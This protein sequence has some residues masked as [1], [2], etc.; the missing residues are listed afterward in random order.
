[1][2]KIKVGVSLD[3]SDIDTQ[4]KKIKPK[5]KVKIDVSA[6]ISNLERSINNVLGTLS[7]TE[8]KLSTT[9]ARR[10]IQKIAEDVDK[11]R[12]ITKTFDSSGN[13]LKIIDKTATKDITQ[14][15]KEL[16]A[17]YIKL[18][19]L[20]AKAKSPE[21]V[22]FLG[23]VKKAVDELD[24]SKVAETTIKLEQ[25]QQLVTQRSAEINKAVQQNKEYAK[26]QEEMERSIAKTREEID[27]Y[28]RQ[29][30]LMIGKAVTSGNMDL[31][32]AL[33][34]V[35][36]AVNDI[37]PTNV[38]KATKYLNELKEQAK[39][40]EMGMNALA[41]EEKKLA[42]AQEDIAN[43]T[44]ST[45]NAIDSFVDRL[46]VM[47]ERARVAG[48][49]DLANE[50]TKIQ[51][52][53]RN[54]DVNNLEQA[55]KSLEELKQNANL[56]T[57]ELNGVESQTKK[58]ESAME[59]LRNVMS[60]AEK[61]EL[62][63]SKEYVDAVSSLLKVE[64]ALE[65]IRATG[66]TIDISSTLN[67]A[68]DSANTLK[69][70]LDK[71]EDS[72][73]GVSSALSEIAQ[74]FGVYIDLG[75]IVQAVWQSFSN[76]IRT[77]AEIDG[78]MR[79][80]QK[81]CDGT[82]ESFERFP[83]VARETAKE[84]GATTEEI[85]RA[86]EYYAKL[87]NTLEESAEKAKLATIFKNIGDFS[88]IDMASEALITIQKGFK[89]IGDS[90]QDMIK[91]M[92]VANEVGNNFTSTTEDI[93]EGLR[94]S[95]NALSEANNTYEQSVGIFVA[96]N[97]SIQDAQKVGNAIKTIA[98]RLRG[99]ETELDACGVP[100]SKLR[101]EIYEITKT[102]GK[103]IDILKDDGLTFKSTYDIL[104]E[105]S[106][107]YD[108]LNDSQKA[109]LQQVIAGKQQGNVFSGIMENM[110]EGV[111]AYNT[112]LNSSGSAM[113][114]NEIY[115]DSVDAKMNQLSENVQKFWS[116]LVN[117]RMVKS[118]LDGLNSLMETVDNTSDIFGAS[119][120][121]IL[122]FGT[123]FSPAITGVVNL[124][125]K[126]GGLQTILGNLVTPLGIFLTT[127][128]LVAIG[129]G[130]ISELYKD[131]NERIAETSDALD[132]FNQRQKELENAQGLLDK[133]AKLERKI[134]DSNTS[135]EEK[136]QLEGEVKGIVEQLSTVN[137][138]ISDTLK[139]DNL[140]LLEKKGIIEDI[141]ALE[142]KENAE[143]LNDKLDNKKHYKNL[144][145]D[146]KR[147]Y[148]DIKIMEKE[149]AD[150][151]VGK[152][153]IATWTS[154]LEYKKEQLKDQYAEIALYNQSVSD[155]GTWA[156]EFGREIIV[157]DDNI[158]TFY[159]GLALAGE[160]ASVSGESLKGIS[161]EIGAIPMVAERSE[162]KVKE[163][164]DS[165]GA[166]DEIDLFND[167]S[168]LDLSLVSSEFTNLAT[169]VGKTADQLQR[170]L[171]TWN[172]LQGNKSTIEDIIKSI[173]ENG[174]LTDD[175]R[176]KIISSGNAD[177]IALLD[178]DD[179][180]GDLIEYQEKVNKQ[181]EEEERRIIETA[182]AQVEKNKVMDEQIEKERQR[183]DQI[184][185]MNETLQGTTVKDGTINDPSEKVKQIGEIVETASGA[186]LALAEL[187][188]QKVLLHY[189][190][191]GF[192]REVS[193]TKEV[194]DGLYA[195]MITLDGTNTVITIDENG[196]TA[197]YALENIKEKADGT[198]TA[199]T[200]IG[201]EEFYINFDAEGNVLDL[202]NVKETAEGLIGVF[203]GVD[204][205]SYKVTF[206][207]ETLEKDIVEV[208]ENIDGTYSLIDESSGHP[209]E[210]IMNGD[211]EVIG[212]IDGINSSIEELK[213]RKQHL[214]ESPITVTFEGKEY[215][216]SDLQNV[217]S[218]LD[219]TYTAIGT[220]NGQPVK[221]TFDNQGQIVGEIR[222]VTDS[223]N[224]A[225]DARHDLN[226]KPF[227]PTVTGADSAIDK[228][229]RVAD[230]A[231]YARS[232]AGTIRFVTENITVNA[233]ETRYS[234]GRSQGGH[235][236]YIQSIKT[237]SEDIFAPV[238]A[239]Q[240]VVIMANPV[241]DTSEV[242][243]FDVGG[244]ISESGGG[245]GFSAPIA[246][247][248]PFALKTKTESKDSSSSSS[249]Q[250]L[251]YEVDRYYKLN[252]ILED[253]E[254]ALKRI[255]DAKDIATGKQ[256]V[257]LIKQENETLAK[258]IQTL[259]LLQAEQEKELAE[260][261]ATLSANG[262][263]FDSYGNLINSQEKLVALA[264]WANEG[265]DSRNEHVEQL[266]DLVNLYTNLANKS[267]PDTQDA[268]RD[269]NKE[270]RDTAV[271]QL[272]ELREKLI[273]ALRTER[274]Q[275]KDAE[276]SILDNRIADL[277]KQIEDLDDDVSDRLTKRTKLEAE[278]K[279]WQKDDSAFSTKKQ[280][281]LQKELNDLNKQIRKDELEKQIQ[282]VEETKNTV[283]ETYDSMLE[284]K[285]LYEDANNLIT[286]GKTDE[287]LLL[288][289]E[290]A[291]DY[292]NIG[293]LW[294]ENLSNAFMEEIKLALE[295]LAYLKGESNKFT[296]NVNT[297]APPPQVS[298]PS[299]PTPTP[300]PATTSK[301]VSI[302]SRVKVTDVGAGIYVDSYTSQSS[303]TWRGA[304]VSTSD[305]MYVYNMRGDKV[306]LARSQGGVPIGWI[307]KKKVKA[308]DTGGY[309]GDFQGGQLA[310]L[311]SKERVLSAQ[312]T[313][314][315]EKLVAMLGD[316]VENPMLQLGQSTKSMGNPMTEINT[317]IEINNNFTVTNNTPFD[318]DRQDNNISQLMAKELRRFG[319]ITKK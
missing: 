4:L 103:P 292:K 220:L 110:T 236:A 219:G 45:Q 44:K 242:E 68:K 27:A 42:K 238:E 281:E 224:E 56:T 127:L 133:W 124:V 32:E 178:N 17:F 63:D 299:T 271:D 197:T 53:T 191:Q 274:E 100:A 185:E 151:K 205:K 31:A 66:A 297:S 282:E 136:V 315:F 206:D 319:K 139:N 276:I 187:N 96:A 159:E 166:L 118:A 168:D 128:S 13:L 30:N 94:R 216:V 106:A 86:T 49:L 215:V 37:D 312:Q 58:L 97:S 278:L 240:D 2:K 318:Q 149:L 7:T 104:V 134:K 196:E 311:H 270:L 137:S 147:N 14:M 29:L 15:Y 121:S 310:M 227:N 85:I 228:L 243:A 305:T 78:A 255:K 247:V 207:K 284:E 98:M 155:M 60:R 109:Y 189:D 135:L 61:F 57:V 174:Y 268:I 132:T 226:S 62:A 11:L 180:Y 28:T 309:T 90:G 39:L 256:Y 303:G 146:M 264:N 73:E 50:L 1:M 87:G 225:T 173:N 3:V 252:D 19:N 82:A 233:V 186:K 213:E 65:R 67:S 144:Y 253:Y 288:L 199:L 201:E 241:M 164:A 258:K 291:E 302:G 150:N 131:A 244:A 296:N 5:E 316:L 272:T 211:G 76:G 300:T 48:K 179:F 33:K 257:E 265:D 251:E 229:N 158:R 119:T 153:Y 301:P 34:Q 260:T 217:V 26:S 289:E 165:I 279:K 117:S 188:G 202:I 280:Q 295:A 40:T 138:T 232:Q 74:S 91:I 105:L 116:K 237:G 114:E 83:D 314:S 99:M 177:L 120:T 306:A 115:M 194:A 193:N 167:Y 214:Q 269:L 80:L 239:T 54:I 317:N 248:Q 245:D 38:S 143:E 154:D 47:I 298:T 209:I 171:D 10:E 52:A 108:R 203:E 9:G 161:G 218:N 129:I 198:M 267:I 195:S 293:A 184:K 101:D 107:V 266:E 162:E 84:V 263:L 43:K 125:N 102:V 92:D 6:D 308:F 313:Q 21:L 41:K 222:E 294:G 190:D 221:I 145:K 89:D 160:Q 231:G 93:A 262:F 142:G 51:Y 141:I 234:V 122:L 64:N 46:E 75:D 16:E 235:T 8:V 95:G 157:V 36:S 24:P 182:N 130:S 140:T 273:D 163:L 35:R 254:N 277:R 156:E 223:A 212:Q 275:Q 246:E 126:M 287:M 55:T 112:A 12:T 200:K 210:I 72:S 249:N 22:E 250:I 81:V 208:Q 20:T 69:H 59:K 71:V 148:D 77:I 25:L 123:A 175:M 79:D 172:A 88:S 152:D 23:N 183:I 290:Y 204:G 304:N 283:E 261:K 113:R 70:T 170:F 192:Y 286:S 111:N 285:K 18:D 181:L 169:E 230:A 307:D 176:N 259:K